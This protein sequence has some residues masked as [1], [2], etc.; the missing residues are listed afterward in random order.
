MLV[1]TA[2]RRFRRLPNPPISLKKLAMR[3]L[4]LVIALGLAAGAA[5]GAEFEVRQADR[6]FAP[7]RIVVGK[8]SVVHFTN[9]E[10]F[11]HHAFVDTAQFS[12]DTG[13]IPPG[14]SRD[15]VFIRPG[16]YAIRCAIHPQMKLT[17]EVSELE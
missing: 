8:G 6:L 16:I 17:V 15:I 5:L 12:A 7:A 13:D 11:V 14:E 3:R 4:P 10:K 1:W 9:D 2:S